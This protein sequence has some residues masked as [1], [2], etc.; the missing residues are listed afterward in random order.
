MIYNIS[1][2]QYLIGLILSLVLIILFIFIPLYIYPAED[3]AILFQYSENLAKTGVITYNLNGTP[4]EGATDFLWM[5]LLGFMYFIGFDTYL[6]STI[7]SMFS[8]IGTAYLLFKI[9]NSNNISYFLL[10]VFLLIVLPMTPAS[11]Q[12]FSPLFFGFFITLTAYFFLKNMPIQLFI[13]ALLLCLVRPDGVVVVLP[14]MI[15]FLMLN[16]IEIKVNL[17]K[18]IIY[19]II[20]GLMYFIWRWNYFGE[21]LPLPFYVKSNFEHYL[22]FFNLG[23]LKQNFKIVIILLLPTITLIVIALFR[24][25]I[26]KKVNILI[27]SMVFIPFIFYSTML[28]SQN[29]SHRFQYSM[30]LGVFIIA[31]YVLHYINNKKIVLFLFISQILLMMPLSTRDYLSILDIPNQQITY[32]SKELNNITTEASMAITEAGRLPYYSK[33]NAID[34]WGL[35]T[36]KYAKILIQPDDIKLGDFDLIVVHASD[37]SYHSLLNLDEIQVYK[38]KAWQHMGLNIFKGI[39]MEKYTLYMVPFRYPHSGFI[40]KLHARIMATNINFIQ[41]K[42][43]DIRY[44]AFFLKNNFKYSKDV[45]SLLLRYHAI[46]LQEF[47]RLYY[48]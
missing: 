48:K 11:L 45:E 24:N 37:K 3:A 25:K 35:N 36:P 18:L 8:L 17:K 41:G 42:F 40:S 23:S 22:F 32:L 20:P 30:V 2:K 38:K 4:T 29:I 46:T 9:T 39:D 44:D 6:A 31:V 12:G 47:I 13:S 7:I 21:F 28:L 26:D 33:W 27:F 16:K 43:N 19:F 5:L 15:L 34:T 1:S 14:L 10:L